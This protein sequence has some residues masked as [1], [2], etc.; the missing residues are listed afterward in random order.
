MIS[1]E[2]HQIVSAGLPFCDKKLM[3]MAYENGG[4]LSK[5]RTELAK[6]F[7]CSKR[8]IQRR[9][10]K[11]RHLGWFEAEN[12]HNSSKLTLNVTPKT[13]RGDKAHGDKNKIQKSENIR[14]QKVLQNASTPKTLRGDKTYC[15][16]CQGNI[17]SQSFTSWDYVIFMTK[18]DKPS[19]YQPRTRTRVRGVQSQRLFPESYFDSEMLRDGTLSTKFRTRS[20]LG[21]E[22]VENQ[23]QDWAIRPEILN[24]LG[25][26]NTIPPKTN[27]DPGDFLAEL[28]DSAKTVMEPVD[29]FSDFE[30]RVY[31]SSLEYD[32][33]RETLTGVKK[34]SLPPHGKMSHHKTRQARNWQHFT[35][36]VEFCDEKGYDVTN[37]IN[38]VCT[39]VHKNYI[40]DHMTG[41]EKNGGF[42]YP[43]QLPKTQDGYYCAWLYESY[44]KRVENDEIGREEEEIQEIQKDAVIR[45]NLVYHMDGPLNLMIRLNSMKKNGKQ[46]TNDDVVKIVTLFP[47]MFEPEYIMTHP[48]VKEKVWFNDSLM[49][50][51]KN[52]ISSWEDEQYR[53]KLK[54]KREE[55]IQYVI[56][57]HPESKE[58]RGWL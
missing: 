9:I 53:A 1:Y 16:Y 35:R 12:D 40:P 11:L 21:E 22:R 18:Y 5:T 47:G 54:K 8:T 31:D 39:L 42:P 56:D 24:Q 29:P 14:G 25:K 3:L 52:V 19:V 20:S 27:S 50:Y 46:I 2:K 6:Q 28:A 32:K 49:E 15:Q 48:L 38:T 43:H 26:S 10:E 33:I 4:T 37:Y 13:T 30:Q 55:D 17:I 36:L 7:S 51:C 34:P 41:F 44:L 45:R 57:N 58:L 23:N